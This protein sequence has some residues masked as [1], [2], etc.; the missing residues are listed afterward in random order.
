MKYLFH[1][2]INTFNVYHLSNQ[3][4]LD[5]YIS[6]FADIEI[7]KGIIIVF[8]KKKTLPMI[9]KVR[10]KSNHQMYNYT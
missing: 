3:T 2:I 9:R 1:G 4:L 6:N 7:N 10:S 8:L 5:K